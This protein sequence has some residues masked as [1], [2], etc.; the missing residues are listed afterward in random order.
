M[1]AFEKLSGYDV[2]YAMEKIVV[3]DEIVYKKLF[4]LKVDKSPGSD[5]IHPRIL[6]EISAEVT[7]ALKILFEMSLSNCT[8]PED[9]KSS[10]ISV[11]HK[12][13]PRDSV[14]NYRPISLTCIACK[15]LE[16]IIRD[17]S[18]NHFFKNNLFSKKQFGFLPGRST[19]LQLLN[20]VDKWT[21]DLET[22][23]QIDIVYI[24]ILK[25]HLIR[26]HIK[27]IK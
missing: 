7:G 16:S 22:G 19:V 10:I 13:G 1:D 15:I 20:V 3:T 17:H 9:W 12:K 11:I 18:M 5:M 2:V 21:Q 27:D 14:S 26:C 24:R 25:K 8:L 23:G 4:K 6:K